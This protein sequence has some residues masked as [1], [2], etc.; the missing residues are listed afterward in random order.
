MWARKRAKD[1]EL[2]S[3]NRTGICPPLPPT[4]FPGDT[5]PLVIIRP[6]SS[7][8]LVSLRAERSNPPYPMIR[9]CF[10]PL[11]MTQ[12]V[13]SARRPGLC[14]TLPLKDWRRR[15]GESRVQETRKW[16]IVVRK[17]LI[18]S[19]SCFSWLQVQPSQLFPGHSAYR[20]ALFP[21]KTEEIRDP[22]IAQIEPQVGP[23]L[24]ALQLAA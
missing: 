17:N 22:Q 4:R 9:D 6:L 14:R 18:S 2:R 24:E 19:L 3:R 23:G 13:F 1:L 10:A 20:L 7:C 8:P 16:Q 21:E 11:A 12:R 5:M 15:M